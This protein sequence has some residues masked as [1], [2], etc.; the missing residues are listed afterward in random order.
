MIKQMTAFGLSAL[1]MASAALAATATDDAVTLEAPE[2]RAVYN[3]D[4]MTVEMPLGG[5]ATLALNSRFEVA[6]GRMTRDGGTLAVQGTVRIRML[7]GLITGE[8]MVLTREAD[9][10]IA[11]VSTA[12]MRFERLQA[13]PTAPAG[14]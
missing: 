12:P 1:L 11:I 7:N 9:G 3:P 13:T 4:S 5:K 14:I 8:H 6:A 10:R 2:T